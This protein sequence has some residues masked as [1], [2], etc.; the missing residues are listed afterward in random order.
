[1]AR[2]ACAPAIA[3]PRRAAARDPRPSI[4]E[5]YPTRDA[6]VAAVRRAAEDMV[7]ARLLLEEDAVAMLAAAGRDG[8]APP[9]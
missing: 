4:E 6:Y 7:A 1:V 8:P 5:R 3:A 2:F 9:R